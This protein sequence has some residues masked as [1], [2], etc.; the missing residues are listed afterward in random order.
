MSTACYEAGLPCAYRRNCR[1]RNGSAILADVPYDLVWSG[2]GAGAGGYRVGV[3]ALR[4]RCLTPGAQPV[5]LNLERALVEPDARVPPVEGASSLVAP[6]KR[7]ELLN[8]SISEAEAERCRSSFGRS[9]LACRRS[10]GPV[11]G[12]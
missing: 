5:D 1:G 7:S 8:R 2:I 10:A 4:R 11:D 12:Q 9:A 6:G 3:G